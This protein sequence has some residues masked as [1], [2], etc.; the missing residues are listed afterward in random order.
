MVS[1]EFAWT[2]RERGLV[3]IDWTAVA[4]GVALFI[5]VA[6]KALR[7]RE[8]SATRRLLAQIMTSA[9]GD[10][11]LEVVKIRSKLAE[12][13]AEQLV[14]LATSPEA[15]VALWCRVS[16]LMV[17]LPSQFY[18]KADIFDSST[19]RALAAALS[20]VNELRSI[21]RMT[22]ELDSS[23]E[24]EDLSDHVRTIGEK[25]I[26]ADAALKQAFDELIEVGRMR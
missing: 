26:A 7:S 21:V 4:A 17:E 9:V 8:R 5:W 11:R 14:S 24:V 25:V 6:D 10:A 22:S 12:D 18:D 23:A 20:A 16:S 13:G 19:T 15:R 2:Y 3:N 1:I